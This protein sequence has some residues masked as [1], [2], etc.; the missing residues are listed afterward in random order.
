MKILLLIPDLTSGRGGIQAYCNSFIKA[1]LSLK[2]EI[3]VIS[4]NDNT[5]TRH[6]KSEYPFFYSSRCRFFRKPSFILR[7]I[8]E[9]LRF[10][11]S[12]IICGHLNLAPLALLIKKLFGIRYFTII[13]GIE[14][15]RIDK[16]KLRGLAGSENIISLSNF[17]KKMLM[18]NSKF[19]AES[20]VHIVEPTFDEH[21]FKPGPKPAYLMDKHNI[22]DTDIVLLTIARLSAKEKYKGYDEVIKALG[23]LR[24]DYPGMKYIIAGSGDDSGRIASLIEEEGLK[25]AVILAGYISSEK[26][27]L[28]YYR[29]SDIFV[30]PSKAE[31]FGI[32]FLEALACG[33]PVIAGNADGSVEALMRGAL[34]QLVNPYDH[35]EISKAIS[36]VVRQEIAPNLLSP[37]YLNKE[38]KNEFGYNV[39]T[40]RIGRIIEN[41]Y[42]KHTVG[43]L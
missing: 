27:A 41:L 7:S 28:D 29:L 8:I 33:K 37:N 12:L 31:G 15:K 9:A 35:I 32:V 11:P 10:R 20:R 4:L 34:G 14:V 40:G 6:N 3:A 22:R 26:Q 36:R 1:L 38:V 42:S 43:K 16:L 2:H 19:L 39:F 18:D 17:T 30:M 13:Y 23:L 24:K 21:I 5:D 25:D